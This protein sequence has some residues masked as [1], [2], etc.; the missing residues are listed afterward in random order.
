MVSALLCWFRRM[1]W[2]TTTVYGAA[3]WLWLKWK[4]LPSGRPREEVE[5]SLSLFVHGFVGDVGAVAFG[6]GGSM[7]FEGNKN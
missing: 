7:L 4:K 2:H 6:P 1:R 5:H 3:M